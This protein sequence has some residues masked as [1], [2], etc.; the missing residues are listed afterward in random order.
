MSILLSC[1]LASKPAHSNVTSRAVAGFGGSKPDV[2]T[3][4]RDVKGSKIGGGCRSLSG[5]SVASPVVAG[6]VS[7]LASTIPEARRGELLNPASMKQALV[8]GAERLPGLNIFEQGA[9]RRRVAGS[10]AG[11]LSP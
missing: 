4:G 1:S 9:V 3:Y 11:G 6:A 8:E 10:H 5:T 7:L 2:M